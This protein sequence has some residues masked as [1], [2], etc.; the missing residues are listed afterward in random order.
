MLDG[1]LDENAS[2][3]TG[4]NGDAAGRAIWMR[5]GPN[6]LADEE[7]VRLLGIVRA[8]YRKP[9]TILPEDREPVNTLELLRRLVEIAETERLKQQIRETIAYVQSAR[10]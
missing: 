8:A 3:G 2:L 5:I 6:A 1:V 4:M 7:T 9:E 10:W